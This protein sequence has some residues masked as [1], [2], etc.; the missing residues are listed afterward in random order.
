M[1]IIVAAGHQQHHACNVGIS[2]GLLFHDWCTATAV[3][4]L[5]LWA[6]FLIVSIPP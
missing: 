3:Q 4:M 2:E 5:S 6:S 1:T